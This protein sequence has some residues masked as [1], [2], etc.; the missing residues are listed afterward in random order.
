MVRRL[1]ENYNLG[2]KGDL[3]SRRE[4]AIIKGKIKHP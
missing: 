1:S 4:T 2:M 3:N